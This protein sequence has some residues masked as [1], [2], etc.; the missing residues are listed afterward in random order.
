MERSY[1]WQGWDHRYPHSRRLCTP[2]HRKGETML[3]WHTVSVLG[4]C[5]FVLQHTSGLYCNS[6][7]PK[8]CSRPLAHFGQDVLQKHLLNWALVSIIQVLFFLCVPEWF[9]VWY[10]DFWTEYTWKFLFQVREPPHS[11]G[12][13]GLTPPSALFLAHSA[14]SSFLPMAKAVV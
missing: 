5:S 1:C 13:S 12:T 9:S 8:V 6:C 4:C 10:Q 3:A 2:F 14:L 7:Q 11:G